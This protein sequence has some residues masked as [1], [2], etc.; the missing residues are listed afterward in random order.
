V[1]VWF[2]FSQRLFEA[3]GGDKNP[4]SHCV[5]DSSRFSCHQQS[6]VVAPWRKCNTFLVSDMREAEAALS[7]RLKRKCT[8]NTN[9]MSA[10]QWKPASVS[11]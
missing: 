7:E 5:T 1:S 2:R 8:L 4:D 11:K 9:K 10:V 3:S 6:Q